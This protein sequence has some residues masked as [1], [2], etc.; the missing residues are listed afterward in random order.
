MKEDTLSSEFKLQKNLSELCNS[1]LI[2]SLMTLN[3]D[4]VV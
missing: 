4:L 1:Y 3:E 2:S